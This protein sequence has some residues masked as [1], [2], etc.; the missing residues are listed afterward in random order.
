MRRSLNRKRALLHDTLNSNLKNAFDV[1]G[2]ETKDS[3]QYTIEILKKAEQKDI[4]A[5]MKFV[6][7]TKNKEQEGQKKISIKAKLRKRLQSAKPFNFRIRDKQERCYSALMKNKEAKRAGNKNKSTIQIDKL[8]D[9]NTMVT[10][11][12]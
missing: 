2:F 3:E 12:N 7:E 6:E 5:Q 10:Q 11:A 8:I 4:E 9:F 1:A